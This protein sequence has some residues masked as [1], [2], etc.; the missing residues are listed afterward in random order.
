LQKNNLL[1]INKIKNYWRWC[2]FQNYEF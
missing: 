1:Y 2:Y